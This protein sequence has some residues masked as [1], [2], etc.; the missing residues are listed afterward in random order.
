MRTVGPV[1]NA[2][3]TQTLEDLTTAGKCW[4]NILFLGKTHLTQHKNDVLW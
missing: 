1:E 2:T 3:A 4:T